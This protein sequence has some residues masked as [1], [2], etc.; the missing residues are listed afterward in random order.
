MYSL[1]S[2]H[3]A[4]PTMKEWGIRLFGTLLHGRFPETEVGSTSGKLLE[5]GCWNCNV[6][7]MFT[8]KAFHLLPKRLSTAPIYLFNIYSFI[9]L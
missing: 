7:F 9:Y 5:P 3:Y 4:E 1:E 2:N 8:G 6:V